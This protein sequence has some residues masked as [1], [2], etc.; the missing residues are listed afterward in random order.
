MISLG[1]ASLATYLYHNIR[2]FSPS[3]ICG[4]SAGSILLGYS[5]FDLGKSTQST[6]T[7]T[8]NNIEAGRLERD[9]Q[10]DGGGDKDDWK[11]DLKGREFGSLKAKEKVLWLKREEQRIRDEQ[12]HE[13]FLCGKAYIKEEEAYVAYERRGGYGGPDW[14]R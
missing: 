12:A 9:L 2:K 14:K 8:T 11:G 4:I 13:Q 3:E 10:A 1:Y 5:L 7:P 6:Q